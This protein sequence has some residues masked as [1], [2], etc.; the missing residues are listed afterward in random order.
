MLNQIQGQILILNLKDIIQ[1]KLRKKY[2]LKIIKILNIKI[3]TQQVEERKDIC[4]ILKVYYIGYKLYKKKKIL[5]KFSI[6]HFK[7]MKLVDKQEIK[8][9]HL[10]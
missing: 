5:V 9:Y 1:H 6:K 2:T 4:R 3:F 10:I 7:L 8:M